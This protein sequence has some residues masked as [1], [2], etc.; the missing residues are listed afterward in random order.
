MGWVVMSERELQRNHF[1]DAELPE[2]NGYYG[3]NAQRFYGR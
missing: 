1:S 3:R 2:Q